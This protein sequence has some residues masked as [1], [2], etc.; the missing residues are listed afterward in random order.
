MILSD[1]RTIRLAPAL[2]PKARWRGRA[3]I[4]PVAEA[5][6]A[7]RDRLAALALDG[8][9]MLTRLGRRPDR[10]G[11]HHAQLYRIG[12]GEGAPI[13]LQGALV[14]GGHARVRSTAA[15]RDCAAALLALENQARRQRRG[16]WGLRLFRVRRDTGLN[17]YADGFQIVTGRV[18][19]VSRRRGRVYLNFGTDWRS[20]FTASIAP[21]AARLF[22]DMD[23]VSR[24]GWSVRLRGE[25]R[26]YNGP[27]MDI[28]HPEQLEW[29]APGAAR[30]KKSE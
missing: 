26:S 30:A 11:R 7:A 3:S 13:W 14:A 5:A 20:D 29:L 12:A 17:K 2:A 18:H 22:K 8:D 25:V 23:W 1:G 9:L 28:T 27:F 10:Y 16:L 6:L 21:R 4:R 24:K 19:E 15:T